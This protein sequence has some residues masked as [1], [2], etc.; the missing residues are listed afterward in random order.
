MQESLAKTRVEDPL[1]FRTN[2]PYVRWW[3]FNQPIDTAD[4]DLQ[5]RWVSRQGFGGV[6]IA[7]VYPVPG[8]PT[9]PRWLSP[10]WTSRA[11]DAK[12]ICS[13][14][15]LGCDFTFGSL[16]PFGDSA[17]AEGET[18][19]WFQG[20]SPQRIDRHWDFSPSASAE[21]PKGH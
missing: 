11:R 10:E 3:W 12:E 13:R 20:P 18:S 6:E 19:Q 7:W 1:F 21:S 8:R 5:L 4:L 17:L 14:L 2:K 9:G 16:W 15:G